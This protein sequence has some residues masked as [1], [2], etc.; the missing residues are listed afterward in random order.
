[1]AGLVPAIHV[2]LK[3]K[4]VDAR[5]KAGHDERGKRYRRTAYRAFGLLT[6]RNSI[7]RSSWLLSMWMPK[8]IGWPRFSAAINSGVMSGFITTSATSACGSTLPRS[9]EW[10]SSGFRPSAVALT[11]MS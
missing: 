1:M 4:D 11:A 10:P 9:N 8:W 6:P 2:L 5:H 3:P 7:I